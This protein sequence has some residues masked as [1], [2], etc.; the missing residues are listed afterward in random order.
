MSRSDFAQLHRITI[1]AS[2]KFSYLKDKLATTI[3]AFYNGQS[4]SP[5]SYVYTRSLIYDRNG[6]NNETNDLIYVPKDLADW[7]RMAVPY[8]SGSTTYSVADQWTALDAYIS[9]DKYLNSRRGQFAERNGSALPF[10]NIIDAR[11]QQDFALKTGGVNNKLSVILDVF[12]FTNMLNR[13]WGRIYRTPGVDQYQLIT[14]ESTNYSS[15]L[16]NGQLKPNMTYR[17][18]SNRTAGDILDVRSDAY[19][20]S[21]WRGQVTI[22]YTF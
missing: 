4:G 14:I 11:I 3:T 7:S 19:N 17:N 18:L 16:V 5:Y 2:K 20:A 9:N 8:T 15:T 12:N 10:S 6:V 22:R 13:R 1:Y 21:R